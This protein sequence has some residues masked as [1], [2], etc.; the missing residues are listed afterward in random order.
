MR[1]GFD[2]SPLLSLY[3][4]VGRYTYHLLR[5]LIELK[6]DLEFVCY[7]K[8]R[9]L[10]DGLPEG[11]EVYPNVRWVETPRAWLRWRG[12]LD[13]LDLYHGTNFKLQ[14]TGRFGGVVTIYDLWLDRYPQYSS[15]LFGQRLSYYRTRRTAQRAR[16]VVAISEHTARDIHSLYGIEVSKIAVIHVGVS[17][18]FR[19]F[20]DPAS[21]EEL[22]RRVSIPTSRFILFMGGADPRKNHETLLRACA[23]HPALLERHSLV[24][25]GDERHRFGDIRATAARLGLGERVIC[26]GRVGMSDLRLLY[27]HADAFVFPSIYEGFGIPVLEAM[28]CGAPVITSN[29]TS[30]P[31]VAGNAALLVNPLNAT[32]LAEALSRVL[33]NSALQQELRE[34]GFERVKAFSWSRVARETFALYRELC[35]R[36]EHSRH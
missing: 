10:R 33:E 34:K 9:T 1:I 11:W 21:K 13:R 19:P 17:D 32:E 18:E 15:K 29:T 6:E 35:S 8:P 12:R 28:A 14:T 30:L 27:S 16:K 22:H 23:G 2:A 5:S 25:V 26:T 3:G 7:V 36:E 31:E 4:G 20:K 24:M